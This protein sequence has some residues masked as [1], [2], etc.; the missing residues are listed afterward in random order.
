MN[1]PA[2]DVAGPDSR[3]ESG[4]TVTASSTTEKGNSMTT[5][6]EA[7]ATASPDRALCRD[8]EKKAFD[9]Q[10]DALAFAAEYDSAHGTNN[11]PYGTCDCGKWHNTTGEP[12]TALRTSSPR[13]D[14]AAASFPPAPL[15]PGIDL[16]V[17]FY[18]LHPKTAAYW[19]REH[20]T[21]NRG[22]RHGGVGALA[23][24][25]ATGGWDVNG[26]TIRF[27]TDLVMFDGQ[28]RAEAVVAAGIPVPIILVTGLEPVAQDTTDTGIKRTFADV[29]R[30][31]GETDVNNIASVTAAVCRWK[32]GTIRGA[33]GRNNLSVRVL[34]KVLRDNPDI[35]D[36]VHV[37]RSLRVHVAAQ[38]S[39]SG[40]ASWLFHN[41]DAA[42]HDFFF[43]KLASGA[44]LTENSPILRL[45]KRLLSNVGAKAQLPKTEVLA[46]F[47]KA[48]NHFRDG[49]EVTQLKFTSGGRAPEAMPK[50]H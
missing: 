22:L 42:D 9:T 45:R 23:V 21:H 29:L 40:L 27:D 14:A 34:Q 15:R 43:D 20:N 38:N 48:W 47:I 8:P 39:V 25:I 35:R 50:P 33:G 16:A 17:G 10:I 11:T 7:P 13:I 31:A 3:N 2:A 41:I 1:T 5:V 26:D 28:H 32:T 24:D 49:N 30:L 37:A 46:L 36:A 18:V 6:L 12:A 44:D 4:T 19:L